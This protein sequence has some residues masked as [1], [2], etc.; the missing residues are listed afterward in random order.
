MSVTYDRSLSEKE[1]RKIQIKKSQTELFDK[2]NFIGPL[3]AIS[4]VERLAP[5]HYGHVEDILSSMGF[6]RS[7]PLN[8]KLIIYLKKVVMPTWKSIDIETMRPI[9]VKNVT[10]EFSVKVRVADLHM[11][12]D[13]WRVVADGEWHEAKFTDKDEE[14]FDVMF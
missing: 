11:T 10:V 14:P 4:E 2:E 7:I 3:A 5:E 1:I 13:E 12:G 6:V 9:E 8:D